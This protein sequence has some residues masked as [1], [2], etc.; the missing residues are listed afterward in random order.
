MHEF[1]SV[2]ACLIISYAVAVN[3]NNELPHSGFTGLK[4]R[5]LL[6]LT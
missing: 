5:R 3:V 1:E 6:A 2:Q 4:P